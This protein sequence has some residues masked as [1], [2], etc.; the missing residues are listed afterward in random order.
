MLSKM[1]RLNMT[2]RN[3]NEIILVSNNKD[4]KSCVRRVSEDK[5]VPKFTIQLKINRF[6]LFPSTL[7]NLVP[8][9]KGAYQI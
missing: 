2:F 9:G 5:A 7:L 3:F 4:F 1:L 8:G 6:T